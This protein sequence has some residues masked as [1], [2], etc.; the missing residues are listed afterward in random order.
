[1]DADEFS[2]RL[3]VAAHKEDY[4]LVGVLVHSGR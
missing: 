1:M 4:D 3:G 2:A